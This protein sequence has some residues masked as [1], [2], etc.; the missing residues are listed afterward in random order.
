MAVAIASASALPLAGR[1]IVVTRPQAQARGL[2][3]GIAAAG[4]IPVLFPVLAIF[5]VEDVQ[6]I[7]D[8]ADRLEQFD[9]AI[10]ISPNAVNKAL[11]V[12][13][14]RRTWPESVRVA[15]IGKSSE[16]EL[17]RYGFRDVI[18][19][20]G[21]FDSEAL[22]ELAA[23]GGGA[24]RRQAR[25]DLSRRRRTRAAGRH[26]D[27][28]RRGARICR[29]LSPRQAPP[30]RRAAAQAV[31]ARRTGRHHRHLQRGAA[32]SLRHGRQAGAAVAAQ[33]PAVRSARPHRRG[34]A[35]PRP[36]ARGPH[37]PGRR[38]SAR[39]T[40]RALLR[41]DAAAAGVKS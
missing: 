4:G 31:G 12:V 32:Q 28:P 34:G 9:L 10:F 27:R 30:R 35:A 37:R 1:H 41:P 19:P 26:A 18:A 15:C 21:R 25:G 40:G 13:T 29:M 8:V 36:G 7:V 16:K 23:P 11:N 33:D 3:D 6:P 38:R 17:A 2:A 14:A 24:H 22:L 5:D 20:Q 39:R